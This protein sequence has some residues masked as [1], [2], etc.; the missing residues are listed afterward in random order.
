VTRKSRDADDDAARRDA[1]HGGRTGNDHRIE[2]TV[3]RHASCEG[4]QRREAQARRIG[5][6]AQAVYNAAMRI[7]S[8][9]P[10][11][12]D[13]RGLVALWRESLLA[14]AALRGQTRGYTHHPQ[15]GRFESAPRPVGSIAEYLRSVH[16]EAVERGY[17]FQRGRICR[18]RFAGRL[19][20]TKGQLEFEWTHLMQKLR[21]RAPEKYRQLARLD[22][23][24]DA[25][26]SFRVVR[27]E[28][29]VWEKG[30]R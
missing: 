29:A 6:F 23:D 16:D 11:Y 14:Q 28:V 18:A 25:H 9:H 10:K 15:L 19:S 17:A 12:L 30:G 4:N 20:V 26:P 8:L 21:V 22:R 27:G 2:V 13:A 1:E 5:R 7:W 24:P 3:H